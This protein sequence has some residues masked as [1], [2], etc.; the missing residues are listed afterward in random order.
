M[1]E[2]TSDTFRQHIRS[3]LEANVLPIGR[4]DNFRDASNITDQ[5]RYTR[6][7]AFQRSVRKIVGERRYHC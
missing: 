5:Q 4:I 7:N 6:A 1:F 3:W 2:R